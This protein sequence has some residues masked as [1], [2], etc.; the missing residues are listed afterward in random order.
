MNSQ[1]KL[2]NELSSDEISQLIAI[3]DGHQA[4]KDDIENK[5]LETQRFS[6][7]RLAAW[8]LS[9]ANISFAIAA[10]II[11]LIFFT[12]KK[13]LHPVTFYIGVLL[14]ITNAGIA[15]F[16]EKADVE[17]DLNSSMYLG[18][19]EQLQLTKLINLLNKAISE[20]SRRRLDQYIEFSSGR[21]D[22]GEARIKENYEKK[23][24]RIGVWNEIHILL[25]IFAMYLIGREIIP[26]DTDWYFR[27]FSVLVIISAVWIIVE[28]KKV[29][30]DI[31]KSRQLDKKIQDERDDFTKYRKGSTENTP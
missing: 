24:R 12:D 21:A 27:I 15:Y 31:K 26:L 1:E 28:L 6:I 8:R 23:P 3:R 18:K 9:L 7:S 13:P 17:T 4:A 2:P 11:P 14:L 20:R 19:Y 10:A 5:V 30:R 22:D 25:P 29:S 16:R